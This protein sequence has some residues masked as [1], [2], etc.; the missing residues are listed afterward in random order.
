MVK[1]HEYG[2]WGGK[3]NNIFTL[4]DVNSGRTETASKTSSSPTKSSLA[5]KIAR[6]AEGVAVAAG[7]VLSLITFVAAAITLP[8]G[9]TCVLILITQ[10]TFAVIL[11][12]RLYH[13]IKGDRSAGT[14]HIQAQTRL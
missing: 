4:Q 13:L 5:T 11:A 10:L 2:C 8:V 1:A 14:P 9:A 7:V 6:I 12:Y 3:G